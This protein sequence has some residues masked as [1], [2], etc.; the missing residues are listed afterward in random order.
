M[1]FPVDA[2]RHNLYIGGSNRRGIEPPWA[3]EYFGASYFAGPNGVVPNL[4]PP[5]PHLVIADLDLEILGG[6]DP[7]GWNLPR[8]RRPSIYRG[9][10][11]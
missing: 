7:S 11:G 2:A 10:G 8:D 1:E 6:V 9:P 3:Q 4:D 5:T